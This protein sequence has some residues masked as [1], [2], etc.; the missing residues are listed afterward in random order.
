MAR[1]EWTWEHPNWEER[2]R[3]DERAL[4]REALYRAVDL[5]DFIVA[6]GI[7]DQGRVVLLVQALHR[8]GDVSG[9]RSAD[10]EGTRP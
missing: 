8:L 10:E 6:T 3:N 7:R 2:V 9:Y 1:G 5:R 4:Y